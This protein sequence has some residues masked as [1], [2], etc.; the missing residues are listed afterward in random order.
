MLRLGRASTIFLVGF[1]LAEFFFTYTSGSLQ[2][3]AL[4]PRRLVQED[5]S[6]WHVEELLRGAAS[7]SIQQGQTKKT[8]SDISNAQGD[9]S[10][11][12]VTMTRTGDPS[13]SSTLTTVL[14]DSSKPG[15]PFLVLVRIEI[16]LKFFPT[17]YNISAFAL[18]TPK[19]LYQNNFIIF[20]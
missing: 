15:K 14:S 2:R 1:L 19:I 5:Y 4:P 18:L 6:W 17:S 20:L 12:E 7:S 3:L 13:S 8:T 10:S 16:V 9:Q 11:E